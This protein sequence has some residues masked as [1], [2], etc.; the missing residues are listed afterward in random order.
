MIVHIQMMFIGAIGSA[1]VGFP[2]LI[3]KLFSPELQ[4]YHN[5]FAI[6]FVP[7]ANWSNSNNPTGP[8]HNTVLAF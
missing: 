7:T 4:I 5:I 1:L 2:S 6:A 8:F 3:L